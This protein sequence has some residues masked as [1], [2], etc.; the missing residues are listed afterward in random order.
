MI[1]LGLTDTAL[2]IK[3]FG[4]VMIFTSVKLFMKTSKALRQQ[5][6]VKRQYIM[7][8]DFF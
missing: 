2:Q 6:A 3:T 1:C 5:T 7:K 8:K 4:L